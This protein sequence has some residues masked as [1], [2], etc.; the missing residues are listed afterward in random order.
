MT[1]F[2]CIFVSVLLVLFSAAAVIA[3]VLKG[4]LISM[5]KARDAAIAEVGRL[6]SLSV[7]LEQ[8]LI[9]YQ[10]VYATFAQGPILA[11]LS[12]QQIQRIVHYVAHAVHPPEETIQ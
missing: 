12:E 8:R 6:N 7:A 2:L 9:Q 4:R 3:G 1:I 10:Q 5:E 11:E